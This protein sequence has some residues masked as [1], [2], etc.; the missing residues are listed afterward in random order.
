MSKTTKP[1]SIGPIFRP[2]R[3]GLSA[4][5]ARGVTPLNVAMEW[6]TANGTRQLPLC[7]Y[8]PPYPGQMRFENILVP[9][10]MLPPITTEYRQRKFLPEQYIPLNAFLYSWYHRRSKSRPITEVLTELAAQVPFT[11]TLHDPIL[12][13]GLLVK[14]AEDAGFR[15]GTVI[16]KVTGNRTHVYAS[17]AWPPRLP[18][19][20]GPAPAQPK[21][22]V[23]DW[24]DSYRGLVHA[25][26]AKFHVEAKGIGDV[27]I[28]H[29]FEKGVDVI[30]SQAL[31]QIAP[32][33]PAT[34]FTE[35]G[36][37][38]LAEKGRQQ[39]EGT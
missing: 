24:W 28:I 3:P 29:S 1:A 10:K 23:K 34:I 33:K 7:F 15:L 27:T 2:V 5:D 26:T 11:N 21:M 12:R 6:P 38:M 37:Q 22:T 18:R 16:C 4:P 35:A 31:Q 14:P 8:T 17:I 36:R 25:H 9:K 20:K 30:L 19:R 32:G 13:K 39:Q